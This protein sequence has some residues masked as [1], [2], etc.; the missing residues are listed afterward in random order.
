MSEH[1]LNHANIFITGGAGTLGRAIAERRK[2][3]GWTGKLTVFSRDTTKHSRMRFFY[4][5]V[6]YVCG[7]IR[8][9]DT[10]YAA[11]AG[12]D[13][14]IHAAAVKVIPVSE[15]D[16]IDTIDV[17]V[18]GSL[19]VARAAVQ[20]GVRVVMGISTDKAAHPVNAYGCTKMLMEK[21]FQEYSRKHFETEFFLVRYGNVL[22]STGSVIEI[23]KKAYTSGKPITITDDTMT[24]FF[25]S[26]AQAVQV[27]INA[28]IHAANGL[29]YVPRMPSLSIK[30]LAEYT[31]PEGVQFQVT[32]LR[33]GEKMHE[34]LVTIEETAYALEHKDHFLISPTTCPPNLPCNR[35]ASDIARE[36]TREELI[37]LLEDV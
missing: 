10:L 19:N 13:V 12:H 29:I 18:I 31:L 14:V 24:R 5:D 30:K 35:F 22:E 3:E 34:D 8:N 4:P 36:M 15:H 1:I 28:F 11:M 6:H 21:I 20:L 17:N 7:D 27:I 2:R 16:S 9:F 25:L 33:P 37:T 32:G 23:W 26:P